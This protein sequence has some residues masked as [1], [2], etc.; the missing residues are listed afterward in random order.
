MI[1]KSSTQV[2]QAIPYSG[3]ELLIFVFDRFPN[4]VCPPSLTY[5][6]ELIKSKTL[7]EWELAKGSAVDIPNVGLELARACPSRGD[8]AVGPT[9][10]QQEHGQGSRFVGHNGIRRLIS[11]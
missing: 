2:S 10:V 7:A 3:Y 6:V 11:K 8:T 9:T 1:T 5:A 4:A